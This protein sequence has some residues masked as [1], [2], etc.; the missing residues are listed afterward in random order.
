MFLIFCTLSVF[1]TVSDQKRCFSGMQN[2]R[3][4]H[5]KR[6]RYHGIVMPSWNVIETINIIGQLLSLYY[7][8]DEYLVF[9]F[10]TSSIIATNY[11]FIGWISKSLLKPCNW[12]ARRI[13]VFYRNWYG[14]SNVQNLYGYLYDISIDNYWVFINNFV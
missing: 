7:E 8:H 12:R 13:C 5:T 3:T 4:K 2:Y 11:F 14:F 9:Q 6:T 10:H 1:D